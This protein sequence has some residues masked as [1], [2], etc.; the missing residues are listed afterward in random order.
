MQRRR[1]L[2]SAIAA[3]MLPWL[4]SRALASTRDSALSRHE[5][6]S[7]ISIIRPPH[8]ESFPSK[9]SMESYQYR[10]HRAVMGFIR[11]HYSG[12]NM[13]LW[14]KT[15][16]EV[17]LETRISNIVYWVVLSVQKHSGIYFVDPPWIL[18]QI[19]EESFFYEF[20]VSWSF[21]SGICQF[22][23]PTAE[24]FDMVTPRSS[25]LQDRELSHPEKAGALDRLT[26]LRNKRNSLVSENEKLFRNQEELFRESLE[27]HLRGETMPLAERWM[28][29]LRERD[30]LEASIRNAQDE[31]R[32]FLQANYNGKNLFQQQDLDFLSRFDERVTYKKPIDAMVEM[33]GRY[34]RGRNGNLLAATAGYNAGLSRT[35]HPYAVYEPYG[36]M[37]N[38]NETA[39]YVSKIAVNH[40]EIVKRMPG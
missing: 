24:S 9:E 25:E 33:M 22:T 7:E 29:L 3:L 39:S 17:D 11:D 18:A 14:N 16:E 31:Y 5:Y 40:H 34:M 30:S 15:P 27:H 38:F 20:A 21:A 35:Y 26:E 6:G 37:P 8:P 28:D 19:M 12:R 2:Q 10:L 13:P 23:I 4:G 32:S 1:I 36:L